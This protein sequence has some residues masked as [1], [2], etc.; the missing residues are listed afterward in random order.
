[1]AGLILASSSPR[2]AAIL[3]Q[4]GLRFTVVPSSFPEE[5]VEPV[6]P[7][8]LVTTLALNKA[9]QV[10]GT[11]A[12]ETLSG[13]LVIGA[14]TVVVLDGKILGKPADTNEAVAM[15]AMLSGRVHSV[16]TGL[17]L[18]SAPEF[19]TRVAHTETR[20]YF[21]DL[22]PRE[23]QAYVAT[24][25]PFDKAGA[26]GIQGKG[27]ALVEK[28]DGCYFNVVGLPISQLVMMLHEFGVSI[29]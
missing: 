19:R 2:R 24:G 7:E 20:V 10:A 18:V 21:R 23:I 5:S 22:S 29:W 16:F 1:M 11:L 8:Q 28:I 6:S 17:A 15:L 14:D 27:A 12:H 4:L 26:Y 13:G 25:E 9:K 3:K